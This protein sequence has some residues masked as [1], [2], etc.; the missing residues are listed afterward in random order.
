[1]NEWRKQG[2]PSP[3]PALSETLRHA[4]GTDG[5]PPYLRE[6]QIRALETYWYLRAVKDTPRILDLYRDLYGDAKDDLL[7]GLGVSLPAFKRAGFDLDR[8]VDMVRT[9][10]EFVREFGLDTLREALSLAYPSYIL[11]LAM[12]TGKTVLIGAIVASEFAMALEDS[13]GPF[14]K[15]ALVFAPGKTIIESLRELAEVP[16]EHILPPRLHQ[17]FLASMRLVFPADGDKHIPVIPGSFFNIVVTNTEK[18]RIRKE[19]TKASLVKQLRLLSAVEKAKEEIANARLQT[20]ASLPSLGIFSDEAHHTYGQALGKELKKVRKTVDYLHANTEVVCV[21]NTTGTPYFQRQPLREVVVWYGLSEGIRDGILKQVS[22]NIEMHESGDKRSD[23]FVTHVVEDFFRRYGDTRLPNGSL[24]KLA[25]YFPQTADLEELRPVIET[26]LAALGH[27]PTVCLRNTTKSTADE[28][29][30]FN[31]LNNPDSPHRVMLLVNIGTEGWNCP[32]LFACALARELKSSNNFVLQA[33]SRCLRQVPG[34]D[35]KAK[36]YLSLSNA[37]ILRRELENTYGESIS[38]LRDTYTDRK[39]RRI[40]VRK[41]L[42][43]PLTVRHTKRVFVRR[44]EGIDSFRLTRPTAQV[45][46][47]MARTQLHL[48]DPTRR[49]RALSAGATQ[50]ISVPDDTLDPYEAALELSAVYRLRYWSVYL[51]VRELYPGREIPLSHMAP[52]AAQLEKQT[53]HYDIREEIEERAHA[54]VR[55]EGFEQTGERDGSPVYTAE[56][57]YPVDKEHL[58]L[59]LADTLPHNRRQ[60][61]FHYDPY[62]FDSQPERD[63]FTAMLR[64]LDERPENVEDVLFTGG[65]TDPAK[66]DFFVEYKGEDGQW[67]RYTPD[68]IVRWKDKRHLI[69][70]IKACRFASAVR[71]DLDRHKRGVGALHPEGR[72]AVALKRWEELNPDTLKYEMIF[73]SGSDLTDEQ[74]ESPLKFMEDQPR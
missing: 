44:K 74:M 51:Q 37:R 1:M 6:A 17:A 58:L 23:L 19:T 35:A 39:S 36:I 12:G 33:A 21:V 43:P 62:A 67:H 14:I 8:L 69:V 4:R 64:R 49:Q 5:F 3:F 68:F 50:E 24:A 63:W 65:L 41:P 34:N 40:E 38:D 2:Y 28:K 31:R 61:G 22:G 26:K 48:G 52:L 72:K 55:I 13:D 9:D 54:L 7:D 29:D 70:E 59:S 56:I 42:I 15:N 27:S 57:T 11:A 45:V 18:I 47:R 32:S 30:A 66:T 73:V 53:C 20:I 46:R 25:I 71:E 10:D 16:Y 60:F